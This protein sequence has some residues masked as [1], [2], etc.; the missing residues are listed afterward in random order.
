MAGTHSQ[1]RERTNGEAEDA[2][3]SRET[4]GAVK[5]PLNQ[6]FSQQRNRT[7]TIEGDKTHEVTENGLLSSSGVY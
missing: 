5:K 7:L 1:Q 3:R 4:L 6:D 2:G